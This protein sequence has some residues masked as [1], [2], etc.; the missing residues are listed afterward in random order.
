M[1]Y[2]NSLLCMLVLVGTCHAQTPSAKTNTAPKAVSKA[3]TVTS[4]VPLADIQ[5]RLE[6]HFTDAPIKGL[7]KSSLPGLYEAVIG[8]DMIHFPASLD[9]FI[10][11]PLID[12]KKKVNL[13]EDRLSE[14]NKI[15]VKELPLADAIKFV[16]GNGERVMFVF[17]DVECPYCMRLEETIQTL[18]NVTVYNFMYPINNL[19]PKAAD[20]QKAIWCATDRLASWQAGV[21]RKRFD[22]LAKADCDNPIEKTQALGE[23]LG[24]RGT[25]TFFLADGRRM[26]G[27]LP[28]EQLEERLA[29]AQQPRL[30]SQQK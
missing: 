21:L 3:P 24:I 12:T 20:K 11:G 28:K 29:A 30:I 8:D 23:K 10:V 15:D 25:P 6:A 1:K 22:P 2:I 13:T 27:A 5:A 16:R 14:L 7:R 4:A 19:H 26:T 17:T 18:D 9:Q